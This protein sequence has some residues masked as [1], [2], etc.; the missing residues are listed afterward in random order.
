MIAA[1][2]LL[3]QAGAIDPPH[4]E[5]ACDDPQTQIEINLCAVREF[6]AAD[7]ELNKQWGQTVAVFRRYDAEVDREHDRQPGFYDTLLESQRGWLRYRDA[8][9]LSE[10]FMARGGSMQPSVDS[11]CRT[12]LTLLRIEQLRALETL[13]EGR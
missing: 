2:L 3:L 4:P 13:T 5:D 8:Q 1:M 9:C 6:E 12:Y 7:A 10:S 11:N